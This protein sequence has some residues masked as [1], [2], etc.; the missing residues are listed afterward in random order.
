MTIM[1]H[2]VLIACGKRKGFGRARARDL[3]QGDLFR[4]SM[5][6][7][8]SLLPDAIYILSAKHGLLAPDAE[9][10]PYDVTLKAMNKEQRAAWASSVLRQLRQVSRPAEDRFTFLAAEAYRNQLLPHLPHHRVPMRGLGIGRQLRFLK[11]A[12]A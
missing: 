12:L 8:R 6:Y 2:V 5:A 9:I 10:D 11:E 3:Y 7:A 4:K 1:R